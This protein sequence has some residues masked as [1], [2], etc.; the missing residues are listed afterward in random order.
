[1]DNLWAPLTFSILPNEDSVTLKTAFKQVRKA[2][3]EHGNG[4]ANFTEIMF[5]YDGHLREA[6]KE[7]IGNDHQHRYRGCSF[8]FS[9]RLIENVNAAGMMGRYRDEDNVILRSTIQAAIGISYH[10]W[11]KVG[12]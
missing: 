7:T 1:M 11:K 6:Y 8:H 2:A 3:E 12:T 5:D 9:Q 10:S 4:F